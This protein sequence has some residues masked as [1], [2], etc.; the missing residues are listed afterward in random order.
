MPMTQDDIKQHYEQDWTARSAG[1]S[2]AA[3]LGYSDPVEDALLYPAYERLIDDTGLR[4]TGRVLDVGSGSGRW[5]RFFLER[6]APERLL[7]I[8]FAQASVDLLHRW[9]PPAERPG[10]DIRRADVTEHGLDLGERFDLINVANVLF[11][12]P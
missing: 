3:G 5:I 9:H 4:A 11:H 12:I 7:G 2:D 10:L 6:F 1:A 8:D